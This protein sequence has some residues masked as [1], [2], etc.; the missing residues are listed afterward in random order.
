[1]FIVS[2]YFAHLFWPFSLTC[3][4]ETNRSSHGQRDGRYGG[5]WFHNLHSVTFN[6]MGAVV[7]DGAAAAAA[8]K[9]FFHV[10]YKI[11]PTH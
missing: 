3:F 7:G 1:M 8:L 11:S 2:F 5:F 10:H 4:C 9:L 6:L